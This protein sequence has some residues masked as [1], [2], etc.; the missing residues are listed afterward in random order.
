[1]K[2]PIALVTALVGLAASA[3]VAL[4]HADDSR[5]VSRL[6]RRYGLG[7]E[8]AKTLYQ[9]ARAEGFGYAAQRL[10]R[11]RRPASEHDQTHVD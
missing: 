6:R 7:E 5:N 11:D 1:M 10:L 4:R 9:T 3:R 2:R 8:E